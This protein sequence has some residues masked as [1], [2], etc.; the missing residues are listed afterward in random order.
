VNDEQLD[1]SHWILEVFFQL[2]QQLLGIAE[3]GSARMFDN[4]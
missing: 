4:G 3:G 2:S 1:V